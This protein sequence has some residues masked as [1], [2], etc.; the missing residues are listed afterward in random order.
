M[1]KSSKPPLSEPAQKDAAKS[2]SA[3]RSYSSDQIK[4]VQSRSSGQTSKTRPPPPLPPTR[5]NASLGSASTG[6]G[7]SQSP[8]SPSGRRPNVQELGSPARDAASR[9]KPGPSTAMTSSRTRRDSRPVEQSGQLSQLVEGSPSVSPLSRTMSSSETSDST[10]RG[11]MSPSLEEAFASPLSTSLQTASTQSTE[12]NRTI[13]GGGH[14]AGMNGT[15]LRTPSYPFPFVASS[16]AT[17]LHQPFTALSPMSPAAGRFRE[18]FLS[19]GGASMS[20][21]SDRP[22]FAE[23]EARSPNDDDDEYPTPHLYDL[24]LQLSSEPNLAT[25]WTR[26]VAIM[27]EHYS[28]DRLSLALPVDSTDIENVPWGQKAAFNSS[29]LRLAPSATDLPTGASWVGSDILSQR[30]SLSDR[31]SSL[32]KYRAAQDRPPLESRHSYAGYEAQRMAEAEED[33]RRQPSRKRPSPERRRTSHASGSHSKFAAPS[34][35]TADDAPAWRSDQ[36]DTHDGPNMDYP[37]QEVI[38]H[39]TMSALDRESDPLLE[40][41]SVN[42]VLDRDGLVVVIRTFSPRRPSESPAR[43][44]QGQKG[45]FFSRSRD[46][47]ASDSRRGTD[48]SSMSYEDY[49]QLPANL[50]S[51]S[52]APSPA[53][54]QD[55]HQNPFFATGTLNEDAFDPAPTEEP[56]YTGKIQAIGVD[57]SSTIIHIPLIHPRLSKPLPPHDVEPSSSHTAENTDP[58]PRQVRERKAPI[59]ILSVLSDTVP[60]PANWAASLKALGP[61]LATSF[62]TCYQNSTIQERIERALL[63]RHRSGQ[64]FVLGSEGLEPWELAPGLDSVLRYENDDAASST[65][66]SL[67]SP[68]EAG[69]SSHSAQSPSVSPLVTPGHSIMSESQSSYFDVQRQELERSRSSGI[70]AQVASV[71][72]A[73]GRIVS[74][75][76]RSALRRLD[77]PTAQDEK[78]SSSRKDSS[79]RFRGQS[80]GALSPAP[81]TKPIGPSAEPQMKRDGRGLL[82]HSHGADFRASFPSLPMAAFPKTSH[83]TGAPLATATTTSPVEG[84]NVPPSDSLLRTMIDSL[85]VQVFTAEPGTG[86]V[87]WVNSRFLAYIGRTS[88]D[89]YVN[90]P[91]EALHADDSQ[92]YR[93]CWIRSLR[94]GQQFQHKVRIR[95]FDGAYRYHYVRAAPLKTVDQRIV[96]WVGVITDFHDQHVAEMN[97]SKQQVCPALD[98]R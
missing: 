6:P 28:V 2:P 61:H 75:D 94:S 70:T 22:S 43:D 62:H 7:A 23:G 78:K 39:P 9:P 18:R 64:D 11:A 40:S 37:I 45:E 24:V 72:H 73:G 3:S 35:E 76:H 38:I 44:P 58:S 90:D 87:N 91:W 68:S 17:P 63:R 82:L 97:A 50:W 56:D 16:S 74:S 5:R 31:R 27:Q 89:V 42:R 71:P 53:P 98:A 88:Y 55:P 83:A 10:V 49:E 32:G 12:S 48:D 47:D 52:P 79:T 59:A 1:P 84:R 81:T 67:T 13:R 80:P 20:G 60:Y 41:G 51:Q 92:D 36:G 15:P 25:W 14:P 66:G 93:E 8:L 54:Q 34:S 33:T 46:V 69:Y 57:P 19:Q 95:R 21:L 26:L 29:G 30:S 86:K 4:T 96:H 77:H 65:L 85:P